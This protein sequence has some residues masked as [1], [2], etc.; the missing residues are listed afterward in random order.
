MGLECRSVAWRFLG[1]SARA[2][3]SAGAI[4]LS[5]APPQ[6]KPAED[7]GSKNVIRQIRLSSA[8]ARK[9]ICEDEIVLPLSQEDST[10]GKI[11]IPESRNGICEWLRDLLWRAG[12]VRV[13]VEG[14]PQVP[15]Q[16]L[17]P[18]P[19]RFQIEPKKV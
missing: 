10:E 5:T 15:V 19:A 14:L 8:K 7:L 4:A 3:C 17:I 18:T 12:G 9:S 2:E 6:R 1:V 13:H 16:V 11:V